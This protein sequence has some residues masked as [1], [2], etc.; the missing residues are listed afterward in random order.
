MI[1]YALTILQKNELAGQWYA[2]DCYFNPVPNNAGTFYI[3]EQEKSECINPQFMWVHDLT[4][5]TYNPPN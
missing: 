2:P 3:F 5:S 1:G 4:P